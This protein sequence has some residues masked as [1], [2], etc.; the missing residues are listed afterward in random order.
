MR[1]LFFEDKLQFLTDYPVPGPKYNEA[2]VRVSLAG[3]CGTDLEIVRGYMGFNG[4]P[5]HEF[6]GIVEECADERF[7]GKRVAGE[8]NIGCG[9]CAYCLN[10]MRSHC[11]NR[12]VLG[13]LNKNGA[14]ADY[15]T[16][17]ARNLH[18]V[19]DSI[20]D[21]EAVFTEPLA[22]AF[23]ILQQTHIK[24]GDRVCVIGDGRLGLLAAQVLSLAGC[25]LFVVGR[26]EKKL[27]ILEGKGIE[28]AL[29]SDFSEG[30]FDFVVDCAGSPS[31]MKLAMKIVKPRG[32][33]VLKT[34]LAHWEGL[35]LNFLV[36][37]EITL[38]GSRCGR[39]GPAI[40][41]LRMKTIDVRPL[42]E[43]TFSLEEGIEA[44]E[45]ASRKGA[46]KVLVKMR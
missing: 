24:P 36:I 29:E 39:F 37:N 9:V 30:E 21:E 34:T 5:G 13:I 41:A 31:G 11:P 35:D 25:G 6:I 18:I 20:S 33:I 7:I 8:I 46:L 42:I 1:A 12:A 19:P 2:L 28:T 4:I 38:L 23:E 45:Y 26:H 14:F 16:L 43:K 3:I 17:P 40:R 15:L 44:F 10:R 27:K 32:T 22:A